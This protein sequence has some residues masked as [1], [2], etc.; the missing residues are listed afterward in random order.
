VNFEGLTDFQ[1][2]DPARLRSD[3]QRQSRATWK[4]LDELERARA[5]VLVP[6]QADKDTE[7]KFGEM[8]VALNALTVRLPVSSPQTAGRRV[9]VVMGSSGTVLV[10]ASAKNRV[11]TVTVYTM[12]TVGQLIEFYDDGQ[13]SFWR[14]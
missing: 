12:S 7:A 9:G 4:A 13:G 1:T 2:A 10:A 11:A 6:R 5:E 8:I 14:T 3:L